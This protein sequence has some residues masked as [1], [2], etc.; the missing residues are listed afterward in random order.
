MNWFCQCANREVYC[1]MCIGMGAPAQG[2]HI[3]STAWHSLL[4]AQNKGLPATACSSSADRLWAQGLLVKPCRLALLKGRCRCHQLAT[5]SGLRGP[6]RSMRCSWWG[7]LTY[8]VMDVYEKV[9]GLWRWGHGVQW[10]TWVGA[11]SL[12]EIGAV[13]VRVNQKIAQREVKA[14]E[15]M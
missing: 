15:E 12:E 10:E 6:W 5:L 11:Q 2:W 8:Q 1:N 9:Q 13:A 4:C 14:L 7:H 3:K